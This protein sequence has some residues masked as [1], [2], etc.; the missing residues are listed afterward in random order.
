MNAAAFASNVKQFG[1]LYIGKVEVVSVM[2]YW[3]V[4]SFIKK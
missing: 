3:A 1:K 2:N 4:C